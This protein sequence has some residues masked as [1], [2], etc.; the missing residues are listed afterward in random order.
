M[1]SN[2]ANKTPCRS[3]IYPNDTRMVQHTQI[4][5]CG[6]P[7]QKNEAQ[8]LYDHLKSYIKGIWKNLSSLHNK[9]SEQICMK[10]DISK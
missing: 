1:E 3:E 8:K 7:R 6:I 4:H 2:S 9:R 10:R 5:K